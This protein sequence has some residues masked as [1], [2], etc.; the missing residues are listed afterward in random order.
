MPE[1]SPI[2]PAVLRNAAGFCERLETP[3]NCAG[4]EPEEEEQRR[5][6]AEGNSLRI[7]AMVKQLPVGRSIDRS[8]LP[9]AEC[10]PHSSLLP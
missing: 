1:T 9:F 4:P 2:S 3:D 6:K 7:I 5:R 10:S 8:L